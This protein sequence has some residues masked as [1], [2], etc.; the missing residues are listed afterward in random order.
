MWLFEKL[1]NTGRPAVGYDTTD[2]GA[3]YL[4]RCLNAADIESIMRMADSGDII[5]QS[6]LSRDILEKNHDIAAAIGT[7]R[8]AVLGCKWSIKPGSDTAE[9]EA[10]AAILKNQ[11]RATGKNDTDSFDEL[12]DDMTGGLL[13]GFTVSEICWLPGGGIAGFKFIPHEQITF[14]DGF[15]P[16]IITRENPLGV[17]LPGNQ[18][19][20]HRLRLHGSDPVRGGLIRPLAWLH[21]FANINIK[22]LLSFI[23]RYGMPF[24]AATVDESTFEKEKNV[25]KSLV[26]NFGSAGGGIFTKSVEL[27]LLQASN[28]TGDVYFKMLE[29]LDKAVN[30]VVLGQ[31]ATS[32]DGGGWS[33]DGAQNQV[34]QDILESDCRWLER[35]INSQVISRWA[36]A[37]LAPS[38]SAPEFEIDCVPPE[39]E[40]KKYDAMKSRFDAAGVAIR[41]GILTATKDVEESVRK[42]LE[43]PEIPPE[44]TASWAKTDGI[45][46][47]ITLQQASAPGMPPAGGNM[48]FSDALPAAATRPSALAKDIETWLSPLS[49]EIAETADADED[50]FKKKLDALASGDMT[51]DS[52]PFEKSLEGLVYDNLVK[53][54]AAKDSELK[55]GMKK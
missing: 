14:R 9:S 19:V 32:G 50:E 42:I 29:Y 5:E 1:F 2:R 17:E 37:N 31:T 27:E 16:K 25:I 23:E 48:P 20:F 4:P 35:T 8:N 45:R 24:V 41:A 26:R 49:K 11:L 53:A 6:V 39:D 33:K 22:D 51:G 34:R 43:L 55:K 54:A 30:K 7:R 3:N 12:L 13:P 52:E 44:A 36:A 21:I 40:Q 10:A 38:V 47:P 46:L 15:T 18:T 28:N